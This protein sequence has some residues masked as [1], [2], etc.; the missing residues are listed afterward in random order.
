MKKSC[1]LFIVTTTFTT[2]IILA[3]IL[4]QACAADQ[5]PKNVVAPVTAATCTANKQEFVGNQCKPCAEGNEFNSTTGS[6]SLAL[7]ATAKAAKEICERMR[8]GATYNAET[9]HCDQNY[10]SCKAQNKILA[11][12]GFECKNPTWST[13]R[14][15]TENAP[16]LGYNPETDLCVETQASCQAK[17]KGFDG[18]GKC[19]NDVVAV[20]PTSAAQAICA[21]HPGAV[22]VPSTGQ[23]VENAASCQSQNMEFDTQNPN[24]GRCVPKKEPGII[25]TLL[26][27]LPGVINSI[28]K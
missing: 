9:R 24:A 25:D 28:L 22:F 2:F 12:T 21:S 3:N 16:A 23:C 20:V 26:P 8:D 6:C 10:A 27:F 18:V 19:T 17:T 7:D 13:E 14:C 15:K 4:L 1:Q 11:P 5:P